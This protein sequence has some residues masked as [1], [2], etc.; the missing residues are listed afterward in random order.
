L[1]GG[2][3]GGIT[4]HAGAGFFA[5]SQAAVINAPISLDADVTIR[6][7]GAKPGT[8]QVPGGL[9]LTDIELHGHQLTLD[10]TAAIDIGGVI[11]SLG[12]GGSIRASAT[13]TPS[14]VAFGGDNSYQGDTEID[15]GTVI[16]RG[17]HPFGPG[18]ASLKLS[19][20]ATLA[21]PNGGNFVI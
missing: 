4:L 21:F 16:A 17:P 20:N 10:D 5:S 19:N 8:L 6:N 3:N 11:S 15:G 1:P 7:L 2:V 18:S 14:T 9:R 12:G 13:G